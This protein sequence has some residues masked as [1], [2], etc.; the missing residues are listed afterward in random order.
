VWDTREE[1]VVWTENIVSRG[2]FSIDSDDS[3]GAIAIQLAVRPAGQ[4]KIDA[5]RLAS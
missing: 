2:S 4:L 1:L 3:N 5:I